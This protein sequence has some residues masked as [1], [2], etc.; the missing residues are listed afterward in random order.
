MN[1]VFVTGIDTNIGKTIVSAILVKAFSGNYWKPIQCG[2]LENSDTQNIKKLVNDRNTVC[3]PERFQLSA[4]KGPH[5]AAKIDG[6]TIALNDFRLPVSDRT[7]IVEGAGGQLVP[8]NEKEF[9]I[10]IATQFKL[11]VI[12]VCDHYLGSLNHTFLSIEAL[13]NRGLKILGLIFNHGPN[14]ELEDFICQKSELKNLLSIPK[15]E[16]INPEF[17]ENMALIL[18]ENFHEFNDL[19]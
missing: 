1:G 13:K 9:I 3:F 14:Q 12:L 11:P 10:D 18:K 5:V 16:T 7:L 4:P 2:D 6:V 8:L 15:T 19:G 17:V